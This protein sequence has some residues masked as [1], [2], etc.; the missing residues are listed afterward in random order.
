MVVSITTPYLSVTSLS[1]AE[2]TDDRNS[3]WFRKRN[4]ELM[5]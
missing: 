3:P 5:D 4:F 2:V 1:L